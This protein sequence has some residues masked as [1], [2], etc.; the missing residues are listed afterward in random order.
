MTVQVSAELYEALKSASEA[1]GLSISRE[2]EARLDGSFSGNQ[3]SDAVDRVVS[4]A[5]K[6]ALRGA[7]DAMVKSF[8]GRSGYLWGRLSADLYAKELMS[9]AL[10]AG[11]ESASKLS[12]EFI[13]IFSEKI[14]AGQQ[15]L[16]KTWRAGA[17]FSRLADRVTQPA[18]LDAAR[19][20][21]SGD[22]D[23]REKL[24]TAFEHAPDKKAK[25]DK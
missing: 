4:E 15:E 8:H 21:I 10:E 5:T 16:I 14:K 17:L 19:E 18:F 13:S 6:D 23:L 9:A 2:I 12:D 22:A 7:D 1:S 24:Q 25:T 20:V 11:P 3:I